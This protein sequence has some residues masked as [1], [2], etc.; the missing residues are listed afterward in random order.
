MPTEMRIPGG[1][2]R[3][4]IQCAGVILEGLPEFSHH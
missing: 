2:H 1:R 4:C 3:G